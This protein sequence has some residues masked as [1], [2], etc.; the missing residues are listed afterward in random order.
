MSAHPEPRLSFRKREEV[1]PGENTIA[2]MD[3]SARINLDKRAKAK[4]NNG[5]KEERG[6]RHVEIRTSEGEIDT[7]LKLG[8]KIPRQW[9]L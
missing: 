8:R 6:E 2:I 5:G 4:K 9:C 7:S 1:R 3:R